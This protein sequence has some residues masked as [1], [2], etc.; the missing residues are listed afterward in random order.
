MKQLTANPPIV[1]AIT[2]SPDVVKS[3]KD[4]QRVTEK[5]LTEK[6]LTEADDREKNVRALFHKKHENTF[7]FFF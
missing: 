6:S 4:I 3:S 1:L 5:Y 2:E 7:I